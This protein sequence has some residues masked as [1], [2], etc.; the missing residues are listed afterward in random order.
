M[1]FDL[2]FY[3]LTMDVVS[4]VEPTSFEIAIGRDLRTKTVTFPN[5]PFRIVHEPI[6]HVFNREMCAA[7]LHKF[8]QNFSERDADLCYYIMSL[9]IRKAN[10]IEP[11]NKHI[12]NWYHD[13]SGEAHK[14]SYLVH[15]I[16]MS[17]SK[18]GGILMLL[19]SPRIRIWFRGDQK[20]SNSILEII[21]YRGDKLKMFFDYWRNVPS[22]DDV[23]RILVRWFPKDLCN[24][25]ICLAAKKYG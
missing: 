12:T 1:K 23:Y 15:R 21:A 7:Y 3:R 25:I 14:N 4:Y 13:D 18:I 11:Y 17:Y 8:H 22:Y 6:G 9:L 2:L 20:G 10:T 16:D 19:N 5:I 24:K